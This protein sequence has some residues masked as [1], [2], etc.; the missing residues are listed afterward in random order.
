MIF[1]QLSHKLKKLAR[2]FQVLALSGPRQSGKTT[3]LKHIFNNL[4]YV[5]LENPDNHR[6][7]NNDPVAFLD[8]YPK[9]AFLDE[10]QRSPL[11]FSYMQERIDADNKL[12]FVVSGSQH[13]NLQSKISQSLAGRIGHL[14][15]L[16][17]SA[18]ELKKIPSSPEELIFRGS[19]PAIYGK[20]TPADFF[21]ASYIQTYIERDVRGI[22]NVVDLSQ[23]QLFL[24]LCASRSGQLLHLSSLASDCGISV[25]SAKKWISV[26]EASFLIKLVRPYHKNFN[27]RIIK[28]PKM[29]FL[30]TGLL[31]FL[32]EIK[33]PSQLSGHYAR[34]AIF[35]TFV[36]TELLKYNYNHV[37]NADI[38]FYRESHGSEIDFLIPSG[39]DFIAVEVKSSK[40]LNLD[41]F[42]TMKN[43]KEK[44]FG[45]RLLKGYVIYA[46]DK[47]FKSGIWEFL[48]WRELDKVWR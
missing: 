22:L 2:Y 28:S 38:Y 40:T 39:N 31:C 18:S 32:L 16:P 7:A 25:N 45:N 42:S 41:F 14:T 19:Y 21:Y 1:R 9:G 13:F 11:L 43:L 5:N 8:L 46:G 36:F 47:H 23:F 6:L 24:K 48:S 3:L 34:G 27:K 29:Y 12:R 4:P 30:D 15:L 37:M 17:L 26:L 35:E 20:K 44:L 33:H 10:V